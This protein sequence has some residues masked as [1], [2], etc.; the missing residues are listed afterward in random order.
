MDDGGCLVRL[1]ADLMAIRVVTV[2]NPAVGHDWTY[3]V[4]GQWVADLVGVFASL[5][6]T[7]NPTAVV[8]SSGN[9]RDATVNGS[10]PGTFGNPGPF[11]GGANNLAPQN[12]TATLSPGAFCAARTNADVVLSTV[13]MSVDY[14]A[15]MDAVNATGANWGLVS[16]NALGSANWEWDDF[17]GGGNPWDARY[18]LGTV[19]RFTV[20]NIAAVGTWV[21]VGHSWDNVN[22]RTYVNG[23]LVDT[24][25]GFGPGGTSPANMDLFGSRLQTSAP[26]GAMAGIAIYN[27]TLTAGQFLAHATA[28]GSAAAY[29]AAVNAD[30]PVALWMMNELQSKTSRQANLTITDGTTT[31]ATFPAGFSVTNAG[32]F[33]WSWQVLGP[34]SAQSVDGSTATVNIPDMILPAGYTVGVRTLDLAGTDQ[35]SQI[36]LWFDDGAGTGGVPSGAGAGAFP[37]VLWVPDYSQRGTP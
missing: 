27:A 19:G 2:A 18:T 35:W 28:S 7:A 29:A 16:N 10:W 6:T 5:R 30:T 33:N 36:T 37:D 4:P 13:A 12:T 3:V 24:T 22:W 26:I 1:H 17:T 9:G 32:V 23:V 8:D 25:A 31:V 20:A 14:W 11:A 34:S 15:R 21:H